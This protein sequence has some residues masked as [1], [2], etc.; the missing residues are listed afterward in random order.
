MPDARQARPRR[1]QA[2]WPEPPYTY[3]LNRAGQRLSEASSITG[4]AT[5]GTVAFSY[6]ALGRLTGYSG[7]PV[8]SQTYAWDKVPNR[9]SKQVGAGTAVTMTHN[10]ANRPTSDSA[11]N[12]YTNDLDGRLTGQ[13]GQTLV[14]DALG[15]LTQV[16]DP[17]T[18][19]N[20]SSYTYDALGR[21]LTVSNGAGL[22]KFRYVG[23]TTQIAQARDLANAVLY[24]VGTSF[25]GSARMDW[26][27]GGTNQ[28]Y[29]GLNGHG[30]LTW[31]GSSTGTVSATL[32]SDPWG[33]PGTTSGGSL[34]SFRFQGSWYDSS[35]ALSWVVTRW[36]APAL[37][38]FVS[39]DSL[40][41][42]L[43]LPSMRHL[44]AYG[45]GQPVSRWDPDG[46][47]PRESIASMGR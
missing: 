45:A 22:T 27:A 15:R 30:D 46:R 26:A 11:G 10:N 12:T 2:R 29:Y 9:T 34:P 21:L 38:R 43:T 6:D 16:K 37:G 31:T 41:G 35:S 14:W 4:D 44:L 1:P 20:I 36:Y 32:R 17:I 47:W 23:A 28:R 33:I 8:T 7:T 24:N 19:A 13:I 3:S 42:D 39:E 25:A 18:S 40:L 5:N